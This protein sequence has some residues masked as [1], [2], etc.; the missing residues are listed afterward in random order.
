MSERL[1]LD[2]GN[3]CLKWAW[4]E[5]GHIV[6]RGRLPDRAGLPEVARWSGGIETPAELVVAS[7]ADDEYTRG[8]VAAI[9]GIHACSF[10][11]LRT[12]AV[13]CGVRNG[14][15]VP[16]QLGIDRWAAMIA[17]YH[18]HPGGVIV[19][20]CGTAVTVDSIDAQG[21]HQGGVIMPGMKLMQGA[22]LEGANGITGARMRAQGGGL[23]TNTEEGVAKGCWHAVAGMVER[24]VARGDMDIQSAH[25]CVLTGGHAHLLAPWLRFRCEIDEDLVLKGIGLLA[26]EE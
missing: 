5:G 4:A 24:L 8:V 20:D 16:D 25:T 9:V 14:Y 7:V 22:L 3:T 6:D 19:V 13:S 1:L 18:S 15:D 26:E 12:S 10:R 2:I 17:A 21:R 23:A 11:H